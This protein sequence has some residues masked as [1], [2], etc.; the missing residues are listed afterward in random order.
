M[1]LTEL[2]NEHGPI[3][4]LMENSYTHDDFQLIA[5]SREN[6]WSHIQKFFRNNHPKVDVPIKVEFKGE[7]AIDEGG[8]KR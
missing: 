2:L 1:T 4:N 3:K 7:M 8:P 6:I 5:V